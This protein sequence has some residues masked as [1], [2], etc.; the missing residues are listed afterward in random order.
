MQPACAACI[1][2]NICV[3]CLQLLALHQVETPMAFSRFGSSSLWIRLSAN[4]YR[5]D[6]CVDS[7]EYNLPS[8][9]LYGQC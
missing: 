4:G 1:H 5:V 2:E 6:V 3:F 9:F 8:V 7:I